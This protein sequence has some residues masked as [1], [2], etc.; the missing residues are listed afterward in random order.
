[1]TQAPEMKI[2]ALAPW[3]GGNRS[4]AGEVGKLLGRLAWC[5]VV[6]AGGCAELPEIDARAGVANDLHCHLINLA[7]VVKDDRLV[8]EMLELVDGMLFHPVEYAEAQT[9]CVARVKGAEVAAL[10]GGAGGL[11]G[12]E[13]EPA[14]AA[15]MM[16]DVQ[17][18]ADYFAC[19]WMGRGGSAGRDTEFQQGQALRWT[20]SGGGSAK[21]WRSAVE[22]LR[23][24]CHALKL[25]EF[26]RLDAFE[27]L[28]Q[29]RDMAGVG[30]YADAPWP[31]DGDRYEFKFDTAK[32]RRLA[33][34]LTGFTTARVVVRFGDHPLIRELYTEADGWRWH[35]L[36]SKNQQG[37]AVA[38]V[39]LVRGGGA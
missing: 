19:C 17:W 23:A 20:P 6:F 2:S 16:P 7:R 39:L 24:W 4:G 1:M 9:R 33:K 21:R 10:P 18:A 14:P 13:D 35:A 3:F 15:M 25:W 27:F 36:E 32:Q 34:V 8:V 31:D 11:F 5:G 38:E 26:T 12:G 29:C 28:A 22:S 30:I 37:N